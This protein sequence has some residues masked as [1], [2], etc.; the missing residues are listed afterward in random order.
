MVKGE[1]SG[2]QAEGEVQNF[3]KMVLE[4]WIFAVRI[5]FAC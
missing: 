1:R 2:E 3:D 5:L 4:D